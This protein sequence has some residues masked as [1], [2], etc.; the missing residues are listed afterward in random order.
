MKEKQQM[1][2]QQHTSKVDPKDERCTTNRPFGLY[3]PCECGCDSRDGAKGV[4]Y[5]H[6]IKDGLLVTVWIETEDV[7]QALKTF[8]PECMVSKEYAAVKGSAV[9]KKRRVRNTNKQDMFSDLAKKIVK[10]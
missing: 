7:Y 4:G 9:S 10:K 2:K 8:I 3:R 5:I 6:G 1:N